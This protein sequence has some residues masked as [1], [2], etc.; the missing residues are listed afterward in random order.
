MVR[1]VLDRIRPRQRR[2]RPRFEKGEP[3]TTNER[4]RYIVLRQDSQAWEPVKTVEANS[5][6]HAIRL[7]AADTGAGAY[8]AVPTH[9]WTQTNVI[10]EQVAPKLRLETTG[11]SEETPA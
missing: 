10:V 1:T 7:V 4:R 2:I 6:E 3:V 9:N 8:A 11:Q 5:A